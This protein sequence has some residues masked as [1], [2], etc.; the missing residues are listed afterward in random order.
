MKTLVPGNIR[1]ILDFQLQKSAL[2]QYF[3]NH[4]VVICNNKIKIGLSHDKLMKFEKIVFNFPTKLM[5]LGTN[6][7]HK[8]SN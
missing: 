5:L 3:I 8:A 7:I 6:L 4:N 2:N 1:T